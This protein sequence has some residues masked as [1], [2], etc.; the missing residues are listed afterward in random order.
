MIR[1]LWWMFGPRTD[2]PTGHLLWKTAKHLAGALPRTVAFSPTDASA[3]N[4][5]D[6][7]YAYI[8]PIFI[9]HGS[10]CGTRRK[11]NVH[12]ASGCGGWTG[13]KS[14]FTDASAAPSRSRPVFGVVHHLSISDGVPLEKLFSS[15]RGSH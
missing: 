6:S 7:A 4:A 15:R 10:L 3:V 11:C 13:G 2:Q 5:F 14:F 8:Q 12:E 1:E 9:L